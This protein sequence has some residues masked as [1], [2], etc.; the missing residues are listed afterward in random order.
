ME[1]YTHK[2]VYTDE[3]GI[4]IKKLKETIKDGKLIYLEDFLFENNTKTI[5]VKDYIGQRFQKTVELYANG[6][7]AMSVFEVYLDDKMD[8]V[9]NKTTTDYTHYSNGDVKTITKCNYELDRLVSRENI[10]CYDTTKGKRDGSLLVTKH[11]KDDK[12]TYLLEA[13]YFYTADGHKVYKEKIITD[14]L[15]NERI[16]KYK[17]YRPVKE[18][19]ELFQEEHLTY[20]GITPEERQLKSKRTIRYHNGIVFKDVTE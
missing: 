3:N 5:L 7:L 14:F 13:R 19:D 4:E 15:K 6:R 20:E 9:I 10:Q 12:I 18:E 17:R 1:N 2:E 11:D 8:K 16:Y